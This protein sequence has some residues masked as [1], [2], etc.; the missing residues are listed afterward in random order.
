MA[1][2]FMNKYVTVDNPHAKVLAYFGALSILIL[3]T[4]SISSLMSF[5]LILL[6]EILVIGQV[7]TYLD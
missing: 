7:L 5:F 3:I 4:A 1:N 2:P 6:P